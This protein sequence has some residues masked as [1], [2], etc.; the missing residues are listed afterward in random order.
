MCKAQKVQKYTL[1][2][3]LQALQILTNDDEVENW[4]LSSFLLAVI[5]VNVRMTGLY[6]SNLRVKWCSLLTT[7]GP[8]PNGWENAQ[9]PMQVLHKIRKRPKLIVTDLTLILSILDMLTAIVKKLDWI[10]KICCSIYGNTGC[11]VFNQGI[12]N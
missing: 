4:S 11:P 6:L 8:C 3:Q 9:I 12:Q 1:D 10:E 7:I 2:S 5:Q